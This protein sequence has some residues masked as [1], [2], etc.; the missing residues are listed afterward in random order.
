MGR[1]RR[2]YEIPR[3]FRDNTPE[4]LEKTLGLARK[5]GTLPAYPFGTDLTAEEVALTPAMT[6][7]K[8]AQ[9]SPLELARFV[10][11][12]SAVVCRRRPRNASCFAASNW[13]LRNPPRNA[14]RLP[15]F[16]VHSAPV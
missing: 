16:S 2:A 1:S 6:L 9:S 12:G 13:K 10:T 8:N 14:L 15:W 5:D 3:A 11:R 7:L 4:W